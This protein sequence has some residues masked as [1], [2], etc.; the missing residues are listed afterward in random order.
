MTRTLEPLRRI[1]ALSVV[2]TLFAAPI[3]S[4]Q[5]P[6]GA[7]PSAASTN[8]ALLSPAAF[9]RL[10]QPPPAAVASAPV[11]ADSPRP[12]LLRQSTAAMARQAQT[13]AAKA[14]PQ[15][16]WAS[17]HKGALIAV[18]IVAALSVWFGVHMH[19]VTS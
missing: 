10:I 19:Y 18:A 1:T 11:V 14:P 16:N 7:R 5:T 3:A 4:A 2:I 6:E 8:T 15:K 12:S 9:A 17:R 13:A